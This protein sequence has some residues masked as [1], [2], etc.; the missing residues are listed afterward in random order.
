M[1]FWK[2][3]QGLG[4]ALLVLT[5]AAL[6]RFLC[7]GVLTAHV[8]EVVPPIFSSADVGR[9]PFHILMQK[10]TAG[11]GAGLAQEQHHT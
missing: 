8:P 6:A 1:Q 5:C 3:Q 7:F 10:G 11:R 9:E 4:S 2:L